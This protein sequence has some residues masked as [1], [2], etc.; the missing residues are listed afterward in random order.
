MPK[1]AYFSC[2][3]A[4]KVVSLQIIFYYIVVMSRY[5]ENSFSKKAKRNSKSI[6][7]LGKIAVGVG[8]TA[9]EALETTPKHSSIDNSNVS[10]PGCLVGLVF[11]IIGFVLAFIV[12]DDFSG[13]LLYVII[14]SSIGLLIFG[15]SSKFYSNESRNKDGIESYELSEKSQN[16]ISSHSN[17]K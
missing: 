4:K 11:V 3:C 6:K 12:A 1:N 14:L 16:I 10:V 5:V 15:L 17:W 13:G 7:S 8:E 2:I 9:Y